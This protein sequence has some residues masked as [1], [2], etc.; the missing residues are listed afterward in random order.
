MGIHGEERIASLIAAGGVIWVVQFVTTSATPPR[1][2]VFPAGPL[3]ICAIGI[4]LWIHAKW[5]H[6]VKVR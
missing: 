5:R 4:L 3:E 1:A 2:L 6:L